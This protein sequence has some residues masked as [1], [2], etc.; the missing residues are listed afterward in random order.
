MVFRG[1]LGTRPVNEIPGWMPPLDW[2]KPSPMS[3]TWPMAMLAIYTDVSAGKNRRNLVGIADLVPADA[4]QAP[5]SSVLSDSQPGIQG[6]TYYGTPDGASAGRLG[7]RAAARYPLVGYRSA[8]R[9]PALAYSRWMVKTT[10]LR[11]FPGQAPT[12]R[13]APPRDCVQG[14]RLLCARFAAWRGCSAKA[15]WPLCFDVATRH[16]ALFQVLLMVVLGGE[17]RDGGDD[18]RD[19]RFGVAAGFLQ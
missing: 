11:R 10:T 7:S 14:S 3:P 8:L 4:P 5:D 17:E 6:L 13:Q 15:H 9:R 12:C 1:S 18:L 19:Y 2:L 16:A